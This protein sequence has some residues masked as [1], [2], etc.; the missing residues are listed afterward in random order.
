M[1]WLLAARRVV[2]RDFGHHHIARSLQYFDYVFIIAP[3]RQQIDKLL[4]ELFGRD[5]GTIR[6]IWAFKDVYTD[7]QPAHGDVRPEAIGDGLFDLSCNIGW[8]EIIIRAGVVKAHNGNRRAK[9]VVARHVQI[10]NE[11]LIVPH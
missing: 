9:L 3:L 4:A 8:R 6:S 7:A 1:S 10:V 5:L 11:R 2:Q